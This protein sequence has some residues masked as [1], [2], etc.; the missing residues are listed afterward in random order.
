MTRN[1][2]KWKIL[3]DR[4][5]HLRTHGQRHTVARAEESDSDDDFDLPTHVPASAPPQQAPQGPLLSLQQAG[6]VGPAAQQPAPKTPKQPPREVWRVAH[7]PW[8]DKKT[9]P[10]PRERKRI[11]QAARKRDKAQKDIAYK[12]RS[13]GPPS[14]P[15]LSEEETF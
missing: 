12:L 7:G 2:D 3:K 13:R 6:E 5:L 15:E 1:V 14:E 8:G 9:N 10:S 4:P 11:Q